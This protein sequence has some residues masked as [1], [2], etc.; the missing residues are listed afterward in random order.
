MTARWAIAFVVG[1]A[2][3]TA[4]GWLTGARNLVAMAV[5]AVSFALCWTAS[6]ALRVL[7]RGEPPRAA[8]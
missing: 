4:A 1:T 7:A 2:F 6:F 8:A 3:A 5:V